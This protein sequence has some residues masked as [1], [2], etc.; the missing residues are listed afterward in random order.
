MNELL[1]GWPDLVE[2]TIAA[3]ER[4]FKREPLIFSLDLGILSDS[5][6]NLYLSLADEFDADGRERIEFREERRYREDGNVS[7]VRR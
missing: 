2:E 5:W 3:S 7:R 4:C 6:P 1:V